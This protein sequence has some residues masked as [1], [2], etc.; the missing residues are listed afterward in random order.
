MSAV[1]GGNN[2]VTNPYP[3]AVTGGNSSTLTYDLNGNMTSDGTNEYAWDAENRLIKITYPGS[4]NYSQFVY[5]GLS[6]C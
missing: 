3:I 2:T 6:H 5:D 4:E 1:D